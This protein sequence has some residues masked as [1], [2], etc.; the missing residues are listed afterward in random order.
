MSAYNT[1]SHVKHSNLFAFHP[2][3]LIQECKIDLRFP[4]NNI[5]STLWSLRTGSTVA[6]VTNLTTTIPK[7]AYRRS[8]LLTVFIQLSVTKKRLNPPNCKMSQIAY[9]KTEVNTE[10]PVMSV[11]QWPVTFYVMP[12]VQ[13]GHSWL[14]ECLGL[15]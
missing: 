13:H 1:H 10:W 6:Q 8:I 11:N 2:S 14:W 5:R 7:Q 9:I 12:Y 4:L 15:K 3:H